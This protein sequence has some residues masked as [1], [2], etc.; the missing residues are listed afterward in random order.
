MKICILNVQEYAS[1]FFTNILQCFYYSFR[2]FNVDKLTKHFN[3]LPFYANKIKLKTAQQFTDQLFRADSTKQVYN[4][5][6]KNLQ[7]LVY[8]F[9]SKFICS[10]KCSLCL[11]VILTVI[12]I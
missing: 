1:F 3:K 5:V 10:Y 12:K 2:I 6:P 8:S 4:L 9:T 11:T 7:V